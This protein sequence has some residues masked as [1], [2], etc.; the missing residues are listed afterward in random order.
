MGIDTGTHPAALRGAPIE[1]ATLERIL[2]VRLDNLGDVILAG[3]ALRALRAAAPRARLDLLTSPAGA[4]AAG[5]LGCVDD[6]RAA[7]VPWQDADGR[8]VDPA[9]LHRLADGLAARAYQAAVILTSF[10]QSPWPAAFTCALARIPIRA[11]VS[12]EFGGSLLTHWVDGL[13][14]GL[15]QADRAAELLVRLGVAVP[16]R[17][18]RVVVPA[19]AGRT[20]RR[21]AGAAPYAVLLPGASCP[22]RRYPARHFAD[23]ADLLAAAGLRVLVCGTAREGP[24][25]EQVRAGAGTRGVGMA[26]V[27]DLATLAALLAHARITVTNNSGGMHVADAVGAPLVA[28]FAGT[29]RE[30]EYRPRSRGAR[31]LRRPTECAPCRAFDC[32]VGHHACLDLPP[33]TVAA[34]AL[35]VGAPRAA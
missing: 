11:G 20:A 3:P 17:A 23:L 18:L 24:L 9:D 14:D 15:H 19:A 27:V 4:A 25:V 21:L 35:S 22:A 8:P 26:G 32:P 34:A 13:P 33:A 16:D 31:L 30:S 7:S 29:E 12:R 10:S 28:L 5:L 1:W 6:V 2:A